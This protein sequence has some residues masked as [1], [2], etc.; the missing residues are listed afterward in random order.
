M[1]RKQLN[2]LVNKFKQTLS[3]EEL[4][5][6]GEKT[7][8][9]QR[10]RTVTPYHLGISLIEALGTGRVETIADIVRSF[11]SLHGQSVQYK[12]FHKQLAKETFPEFMRALC[13]RLMGKLSEEVLRFDSASPFSRFSHILVHDGSSFAVHCGLQEVFPGRFT[14]YTPAAV[15]L[16]VTMDV[17]S[18][19]P[20]VV[21]LTPD[22][23]AEVHYAPPA[24]Q[25]SGGL[26]LADRMF[27]IK[28]YLAEI[29]RQGGSYV[30]KAR[31]VLNPVIR[32][33]LDG[34]GN[35][36]KAWRNQRLK[37]M[38]GKLHR[39]P[40]VD[41]DV[42]WEIPGGTLESRLLVTWNETE[43]RPRYL[44]TNLPRDVFSLEQ[45]C[46]AYRL[47][48]Q[49]ELMFKEWKSYAN[50]HAFVTEKAPI[51]EGL[52]WAALCAAMMK[53]FLAHAAQRLYGVA[54]STRKAAMALRYRLT[55]MLHTLLTGDARRL[56]TVL[57][58]T[59]RFL[60]NNAQRAHPKRERRSGRSKLGL[61]PVFGA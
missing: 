56:G 48:W 39:Y 34:N 4:E 44:A 29:A 49:V 45:V 55:A 33:A 6:L 54:I 53:R 36:I 16:H 19:M 17:L 18:E 47:R 50:L 12:P 26:L 11:N 28:E 5:Q 32:C 60:A 58:D 30:V 59:L 61:K 15:E 14:Q 23:A 57:N 43:E 51:A 40:T 22:T 35:E 21:T 46:D 24:S 20:Q 3:E 52:I 10:R 41:M 31:G 27:F 42:S 2:K 9:C 1:E 25:V 8:F 13:E 7:G 37:A 38:E